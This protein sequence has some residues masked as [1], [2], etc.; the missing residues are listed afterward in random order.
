MRTLKVL[1]YGDIYLN[2][3]DG[4]TVWLISMAQMLT[5]NQNI[6]VDLLIKAPRKQKYL[7]EA[8]DDIPNLHLIE[9]YA[10]KERYPFIPSNRL[11]VESAV[12][13]MDQLNQE[14]AYHLI[15]IRGQN[16]TLELSKISSLKEKTVPYITDFRHSENEST[17]E[18]RKNLKFI[19]DEFQHIFLQTKETKGAF[20][21]L[22]KVDGQK[23]VLLSPMVPNVE[24][25]PQF[26]NKN[27]QLVYAGKFHEDWH[28][29]EI[30]Q[31]AI[32]MEERQKEINFLI[33]GD[34]FQDRLREKENV[35]RIRKQWRKNIIFDKHGSDIADWFKKIC[36]LLSTSDYEGSHVAVSE[37]MASGTVPI[38]RNWKGAET[39]YPEE[40][41]QP[42]VEKMV[43]KIEQV[44]PTKDYRNGLKRFADHKFSKEEICE[45]IETLIETLYKI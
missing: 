31:A 19:Y 24:E 20:Q 16:L 22:L 2:F 23:V 17:M 41:I 14:N 25:T 18:E 15:I 6:K 36:Y 4:S 34:K 5:Q 37:A 28:T 40:F 38:I 44:V 29:E 39:I 11:D 21:K 42:T 30:I 1:L 10:K 32:N 8:L 9:P 12:K 7:I 13:I 26:Q 35:I 33:I 3:M 27:N 45:E 43:E